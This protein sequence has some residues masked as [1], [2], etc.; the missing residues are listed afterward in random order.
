MY[1]ARVVCNIVDDSFPAA[2][3]LPLPLQKLSDPSLD[4]SYLVHSSYMNVW[5]GPDHRQHFVL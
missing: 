3:S 5:F 4:Y 1:V 2:V